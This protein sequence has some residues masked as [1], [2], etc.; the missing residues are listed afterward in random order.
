VVWNICA[1][2][3]TLLNMSRHILDV[4]VRAEE[5]MIFLGPDHP[6]YALLADLVSSVRTA[7]QEGYESG[8]HGA[9][10]NPYA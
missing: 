8:G 7:W 4:L 3:D 6:S 9:A 1:A 5:E 10:A 2:G